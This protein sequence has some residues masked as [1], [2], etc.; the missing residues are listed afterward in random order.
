MILGPCGPAG[1]D[2]AYSAN[3]DRR[4]AVLEHKAR[5]SCLCRLSDSA[6]VQRGRQHQHPYPWV[7]GQES[8]RRVRTLDDRHRDVHEHD[9][10]YCRVGLV[11]HLRTVRAFPD[12]NNSVSLA[13]DARDDPAEEFMII[14]N[15]NPDH[16]AAAERVL[17]VEA[18]AVIEVR[19]SRRRSTVRPGGTLQHHECSHA[20]ARPCRWAT[21]EWVA[22]IPLQR[23]D[24]VRRRSRRVRNGTNSW[25]RP[26]RVGVGFGFVQRCFVRRGRPADRIGSIMFRSCSANIARSE[27]VHSSDVKLS[28]HGQRTERFAC[29]A[30]ISH[31]AGPR[32]TGYGRAA[33]EPEATAVTFASRPIGP[34]T[35]AQTP[36]THRRC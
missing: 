21:R 34:L 6:R 16:V 11:E 2:G 24:F 27:Q 33:T 19:R 15:Q 9:I 20:P 32:F 3:E 8:T 5:R 23:P 4:I 7:T 29:T 10:G 22:W 28:D 25:A 13:E 1:G 18:P 35:P 31:S 14:N 12:D 17:P 26:F 30:G 36:F